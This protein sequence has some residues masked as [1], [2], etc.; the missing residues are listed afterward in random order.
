[1][2]EPKICP[3]CG[4]GGE[5]AT[6]HKFTCPTCGGTGMV[7]DQETYDKAAAAEKEAMRRWDAA[8]RASEQRQMG[9]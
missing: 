2:F 3:A 4:G 8:L 5:L 1:M 6:S 7:S 9:G